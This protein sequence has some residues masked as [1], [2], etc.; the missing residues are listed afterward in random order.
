MHR[1]VVQRCGLKYR[2][3]M[4]EQADFLIQSAVGG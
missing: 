1:P 4:T 2:G 3:S